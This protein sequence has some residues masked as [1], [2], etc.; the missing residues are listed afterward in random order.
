[1]RLFRRD[2]ELPTD[3]WSWWVTERDRLATAIDG[4][5]GGRDLAGEITAAVQTIHPEMAWGLAPGRTARHAFFVTPEGRADLRRLAL[6]WLET[7]PPPDA[8]WEFHASRQ[9]VPTL[10]RLEI[11]G[12][13]VDLGAMQAATAWDTARQRLDVRLWRPAFSGLQ[14]QARLQ[15][16]FLFLD[17]V[18]GEDEVERWIGR[19][20]VDAD[21]SNG[22]GPDELG[23]EIERHR[24]EPAGDESWILGRLDGPDGPAI[25]MSN[26]ALKRIDHPFAGIH[27]T[28]QE[29]IPGAGMPS[30]ADA[31]RLNAEEDDLVRRFEAIGAYAGRTTRPG[32]RTMHFVAATVDDVKGVIDPWAHDLPDL[33]GSRKLKVGFAEDVHWRFRQR[34]LGLS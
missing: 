23:A 8:T 9:A 31:A 10:K 27:V 4:G 33:E 17:N 22:Q 32:L 21:A 28:V 2:P 15:V 6:R 18:L 25:V 29:A 1:M 13:S 7:A 20:E 12:A 24:T 19:I 30:D 5:T 14:Q 3:F 34:D 16:A 11:A 26:A